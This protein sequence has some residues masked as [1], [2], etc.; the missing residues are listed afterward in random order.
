MWSC[1]WRKSVRGA[2]KTVCGDVMPSVRIPAGLIVAATFAAFIG[3]NLCGA[4]IINL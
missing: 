1:H 4:Y 2:G 3:L